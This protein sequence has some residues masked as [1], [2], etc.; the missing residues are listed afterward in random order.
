MT[1]M[2]SNMQQKVVIVPCS[3]IGKTYGTVSREAAY[4]VT[5]DMRPEE[6]QLVALSMLVLG[7]EEARAAVAAFPAVTIDGCKLACATKM[8]QESGG[9]VMQDFAVLDVYRRYRQFKPQGI[10]ELNEGGLQLAGA[11]ADEIASVVDRLIAGSPDS[12]AQNG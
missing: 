3:G 12:E 7:D 1:E 9:T 8:V 4:I 5:E 11:L 6:T 10:A 2:D